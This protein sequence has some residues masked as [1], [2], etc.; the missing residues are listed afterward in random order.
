MYYFDKIFLTKFFI[1]Y[2]KRTSYEIFLQKIFIKFFKRENVIFFDN[3]LSFILINSWLTS[4]S[5]VLLFFDFWMTWAR[6]WRWWP[7]AIFSSPLSES[8]NALLV[9]FICKSKKKIKISY[10]LNICRMDIIWNSL[11]PV[12]L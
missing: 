3:L 1:N 5:P 2:L 11:W 6:S 9:S 8:L 7:T 12:Y 4:S 10:Y